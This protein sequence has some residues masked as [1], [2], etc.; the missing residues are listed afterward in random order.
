[1]T[2]KL[3]MTMAVALIAAPVFGQ[4]RPVELPGGYLNV[5]GAVVRL[6]R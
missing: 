5:I 2:I 1:M 3:L 4:D 6:G